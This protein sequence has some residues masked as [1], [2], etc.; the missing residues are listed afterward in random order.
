MCFHYDEMQ[1]PD[2]DSGDRSCN[3]VGELTKKSHLLSALDSL[4]PIT[5]EGNLSGKSVTDV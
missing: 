1:T 4:D 5:L 3:L 2:I